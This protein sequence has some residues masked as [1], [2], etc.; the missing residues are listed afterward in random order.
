MPAF[1]TFAE[2][3]FLVDNWSQNLLCLPSVIA[4][5]AANLPTLEMAAI[6]IRASAILALFIHD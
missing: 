6:N 1:Q 2:P 4:V 3:E 5:I